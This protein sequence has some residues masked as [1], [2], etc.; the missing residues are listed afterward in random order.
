MRSVVRRFALTLSYLLL[1][2]SH[3]QGQQKIDSLLQQL[4]ISSGKEAM[5]INIQ[6]CYE[7]GDIGDELNNFRHAK[8]AFS[9]ANELNDSLGIIKAG[10]FVGRGYKTFNEL[11]SAIK[12]LRYILPIAKG[13]RFALEHGQLLNT[14]GITYVLKASYA[15]ALRCNFEALSVMEKLGNRQWISIVLTNIGLV[16][17]KIEDTAKALEYFKRSYRLKQAIDYDVDLDMLL[18]NMGLCYTS[19]KK[20]SEAENHIKMALDVCKMKCTDYIKLQAEFALGTIAFKEKKNDVAKTHFLRSY[21]LAK[22]TGTTRLQFDNVVYLSQ[23]YQKNNQFQKA[24]KYLIEAEKVANKTAYDLEAIKLYEQFF[25]LYEKLGNQQKMA[26][27]QKKY[28]Q[29]KD[30]V[31]NE[32]Y[33]N[34]LMRVQAEYLEHENK[35]RLAAQQQMLDLKDKIIVRQNLLNILVGMAAILLISIVFV[36]YQNNKQRKKANQLLDKKVAERTRELESS[37]NQLC[38]KFEEEDLTVKKTITDVRSAVATM[39]GLRSLSIKENANSENV[40]QLELLDQTLDRLVE[41]LKGVPETVVE[42]SEDTCN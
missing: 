4:K 21:S 34:N 39:E 22:E 18:I 24:E 10:R 40:K 6:L 8:I 25:R 33:T 7:Y 41:V 32:K 2:I 14:L 9:I 3:L 13:S 38:K 35:A 36:L 29:L 17:Y 5:D 1:L 23:I 15:E 42:S 12:V 31:Y 20:Y 37:Y 16:Y 30:S 26:L 11:D 27:Y 28:I 19:L